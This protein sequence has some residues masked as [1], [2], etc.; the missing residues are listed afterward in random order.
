MIPQSYITA[1]RKNV[2]WKED[3]QVEQD[4]I[5]HRAIID[6]FS[7]DFIKDRLAF[8]GGT[9]LH[10]LF[11]FPSARYSEGIDLVRLKS[12]PISPI[13]ECIREKL[14]FLEKPRVIQKEHKNTISYR[15][16]SEDG[17]PLRLKIEVNTIDCFSI[18]N[19]QNILVKLSSEWYKGEALIPT[20]GLNELLATKLRAL[21]QRSKG[22]DLFD[23]WYAIKNTFV[24]V[25]KVITVFKYYMN[26]E[27]NTVTQTEILENIKI[28]IEDAE[29]IG[30]MHGLLRTGINFDINEA[31]NYIKTNLLKKI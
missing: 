3:Y 19:L 21:Y 15:I 28:K 13:I 2:P 7:D 17:V 10:K 18:Y 6:L 1:W 31:Y 29:F 23:L 22:R 26:K 16:Q 30:D 8:C 9:A 5:I 24:D 4:L 25:D 12:E 11:L 14:S 27:G 20:Y